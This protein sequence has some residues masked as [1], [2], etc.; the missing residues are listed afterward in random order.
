MEN[1]TSSQLTLADLASLHNIIEA[2]TQRGAFKANELT[3]VGNVYDKLSAFLQATQK[4]QDEAAAKAAEEAT[5][6]GAELPPV[7]ETTKGEA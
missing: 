1:T 7:D 3:A 6:S 4:A 5:A 2:A